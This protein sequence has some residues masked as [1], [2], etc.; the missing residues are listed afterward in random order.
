MSEC[1]RLHASGTQVVEVVN[2]L[3]DLERISKKKPEELKS[4]LR[5]TLAPEQV[6]EVL[7]ARKR[8][9]RKSAK[10]ERTLVQK[11]CRPFANGNRSHI[12][13]PPVP[14]SHPAHY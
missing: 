5:D 1:E 10:K 6:A 2:K 11:K 4:I 12:S 13:L 14:L 3:A 8:N 9:M 7:S